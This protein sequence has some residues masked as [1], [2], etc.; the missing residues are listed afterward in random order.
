MERIQKEKPLNLENQYLV[1][2]CLFFEG[3]GTV[4]IYQDFIKTLG[5]VIL[6]EGEYAN[7]KNISLMEIGVLKTSKDMIKKNALLQ[8]R[9]L[10]KN[11]KLEV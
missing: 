8:S 9:G 1:A 4:I 10:F 7:G 11:V 3:H 5:K 6:S 2:K